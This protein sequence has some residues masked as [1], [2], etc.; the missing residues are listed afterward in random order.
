MYITLSFWLVIL[1]EK[2]VSNIHLYVQLACAGL[3]KCFHNISVFHWVK[4]AYAFSHF[5]LIHNPIHKFI[6]TNKTINSPINSP[7]NNSIVP[8]PI[9]L[10]LSLHA[11]TRHYSIAL[12][13]SNNTYNNTTHANNTTTLQHTKEP[14]IAN[15]ITLQH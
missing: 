7:V 11:T 4:L 14:A 3:L 15:I 9:T 6:H 1:S 10:L 2:L 13:G 12:N 8:A 5:P